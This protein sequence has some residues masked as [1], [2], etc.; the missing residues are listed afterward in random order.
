MS[1]SYAFGHPH[2]TFYSKRPTT[3]TSRGGAS[4]V[5]PL[6][7]V[8]SFSQS[9]GSTTSTAGLHHSSPRELRTFGRGGAGDV[10]SSSE[11]AI[12]SFDEELERQL[13]REK[14]AAPI[15]HVGRGGAGNMRHPGEYSFARK[16]SETSSIRSNSSADSENDRATDKSRRNIETG[17]GKVMDISS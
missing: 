11:L 14:E 4:N 6:D 17:W 13:K 10:Y 1:S 12:F 16:R 3:H 7:K 15:F 8:T 9:A 5:A 2:S